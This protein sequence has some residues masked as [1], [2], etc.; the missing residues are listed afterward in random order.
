MTIFQEVTELVNY[1]DMLRLS[2]DPNIS[3]REMERVLRCSHHTID[4]ALAAAKAK[5]V[6]WPLD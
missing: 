3:K 5:G 2:E 1:R 6:R 4:E